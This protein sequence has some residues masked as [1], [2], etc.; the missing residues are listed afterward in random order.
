MRV[1]AGAEYAVLETTRIFLGL[2]YSY[3]FLNSISSGAQG[4]TSNYRK[5]YAGN[6]DL[7]R[8]LPLDVRQHRIGIEV[9]VLF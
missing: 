1:G 5:Y 2:Y 7:P 3:D 9:G 8:D 4:L 6:P